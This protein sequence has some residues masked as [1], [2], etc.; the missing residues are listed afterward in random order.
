MTKSTPIRLDNSTDWKGSLPASCC[1]S[2]SNST[3]PVKCTTENAYKAGCRVEATSFA[4]KAVMF[5]FYILVVG[6]VVEFV[7]IFAAVWV[8]REATKYERLSRG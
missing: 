8:A 6:F 7:C 4:E 5:T 2:S 3:D 1:P